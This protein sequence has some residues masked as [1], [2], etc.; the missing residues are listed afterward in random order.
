MYKEITSVEADNIIENRI[1]RGQ[2]LLKDGDLF[3]G[4]DNST[5]DA[6]TEE[7]KKKDECVRWLAGEDLDELENDEIITP[8]VVSHK[9]SEVITINKKN[10]EKVHNMTL[11]VAGAVIIAGAWKNS[12]LLSLI[13]A[14]TNNSL[15][16]G[17]LLGMLVTGVAVT[18]VLSE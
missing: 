16:F 14:N 11:I 13:Y 6:W 1:P 18:K 9:N 10:M 5:G 15:I 4:I 8:T 17:M 3:V 7:F 2:F 12:L